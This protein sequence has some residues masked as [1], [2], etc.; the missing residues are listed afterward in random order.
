MCLSLCCCMV[1]VSRTS[2]LMSTWR[3][4]ACVSWL[5]WPRAG[6]SLLD[7]LRW[8]DWWRGRFLSDLGHSQEL[9]FVSADINAHQRGPHPTHQ[10]ERRERMLSFPPH[11]ESYCSSFL[12]FLYF[13]FKVYLLVYN[14]K[15][16]MYTTCLYSIFIQLRHNN[17]WYWYT[18]K[19]VKFFILCCSIVRWIQSKSALQIWPNK[20]KIIEYKAIS[21]HQMLIFC[22]WQKNK[23]IEPYAMLHMDWRGCIW[24]QRSVRAAG[25]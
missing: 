3:G 6:H 16:Q 21:I 14:N 10:L 8:R 13:L 7:W 9:Q 4:T 25:F 1:E 11:L 20:D 17:N 22:E 24:N 2:T 5:V 19:N 18:N 23:E 15:T 12:K